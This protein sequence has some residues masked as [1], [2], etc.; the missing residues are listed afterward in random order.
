MDSEKDLFIEGIQ[1]E[2]RKIDSQWLTLHYWTIISVVGVGVFLEFILA[3]VLYVWESPNVVLSFEA[4][5]IRYVLQPFLINTAWLFVSFFTMKSKKLRARSRVYLLS[6]VLIGISAVFYTTHYD[7]NLY[8]VFFAPTLFTA[9][10]GEYL[11]TSVVTALS[12]LIKTSSDILIYQNNYP[13]MPFTEAV[14]MMQ[15]LISTLLL[16]FFYAI[17]MVIIHFQKKKN[18]TVVQKEVKRQQ[19]ELQLIT[20]PLTGI[21]N[22]IALRKT[23]QQIEATFS[24]DNYFFAMLDL[25]HFKVLNDTLGHSKGDEC[26]EEIGALLKANST[27]TIVPFRFGGD[28][29]CIVFKNKS[30]EEALSICETIRLELKENIL[31]RLQ[32][33]LTI[34]IGIAEYSQQAFA[35]DLLFNADVALYHAKEN[36]DTVFVYQMTKTTNKG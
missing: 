35:E 7:F 24:T 34:S 30:L 29:F 14:T 31:N 15:I 19:L 21:N 33:S 17:S 8:M 3:I 22:R 5:T 18:D 4:Y 26:L 9:I 13:D 6:I 25:D 28:E 1:Q 2:Q 36:R 32:L 11:L 12:V 16:I 23:F 10:Y 20:D 27:E